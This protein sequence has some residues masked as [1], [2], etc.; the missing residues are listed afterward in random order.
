MLHLVISVGSKKEI[1]AKP[2][3]DGKFKIQYLEHYSRYFHKC[4]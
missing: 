2:L 3:R 4:H 1:K